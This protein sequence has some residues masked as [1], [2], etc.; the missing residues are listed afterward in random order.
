MYPKKR[1]IFHKKEKIL[2]TWIPKEC[3]HIAL[4]YLAWN[5]I[6][7]ILHQF[8]EYKHIE[9]D[10]HERIWTNYFISILMEEIDARKKTMSLCEY[11]IKI[12]NDSIIIQ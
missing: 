11:T 3:F 2:L 4:S 7:N 5:C 8:Q 9:K 10:I 12:K 1:K 6:L